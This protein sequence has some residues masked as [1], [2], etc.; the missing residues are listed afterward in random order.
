MPSARS[1]GS[2]GQNPPQ[3]RVNFRSFFDSRIRDRE[4]CVSENC[5]KSAIFGLFTKNWP[6]KRADF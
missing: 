4:A 1:E 5:V 2:C 6:L 3:K